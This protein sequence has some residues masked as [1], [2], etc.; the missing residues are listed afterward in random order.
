VTAILNVAT[1]EGRALGRE[2][3]RLCDGELKNKPDNRCGTCAG[4]GGDHLANGSPATLMSFVKSI[5]ERT[6]F[7]CH[8][9]DRPCAAWLALRFSKPVEVPW[10]HCQVADDAPWLVT[11][12]GVVVTPD[13]RSY[14]SLLES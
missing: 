11:G 1:P 3:A 9:H 4:R 12:D 13:A 10:D 8:E 6:P 2:I 5:A 7:W 14:S